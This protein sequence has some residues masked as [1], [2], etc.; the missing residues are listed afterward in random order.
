M[1]TTIRER[2]LKVLAAIYLQ[3][4]GNSQW[5]DEA[6]HREEQRQQ[7]AGQA[8]DDVPAAEEAVLASQHAGRGQNQRLLPAEAVRVVVVLHRHRYQLAST[9]VHLDPTVQ[10]PE[11]RQRRGSHPHDQVLLLTQL[12]NSQCITTSEYQ[13]KSSEPIYNFRQ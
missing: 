1:N 8:D 7:E 10:L 9:E 5:E 4:Q 11:R 6:E 13:T 2:K 3:S 12:S